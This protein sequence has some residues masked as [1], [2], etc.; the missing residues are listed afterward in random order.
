MKVVLGSGV[1]LQG[2]IAGDASK[3]IDRAMPV[4]EGIWLRQYGDELVRM[5][6]VA[7]ATGKR[8]WSCSMI[9][10]SRC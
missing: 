9:T 7:Q 6:R 3:P 8:C 4:D 5:A 1:G 2:V 10:N